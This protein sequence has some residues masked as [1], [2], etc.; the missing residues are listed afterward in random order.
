M[1]PTPHCSLG[2]PPH[3]ILTFWGRGRSCIFSNNVVGVGVLLH[4]V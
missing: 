2:I 4:T 3:R 1:A